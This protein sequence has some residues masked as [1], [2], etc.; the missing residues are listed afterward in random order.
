MSK[1]HS[2]SSKIQVEN[3]FYGSMIKQLNIQDS[4]IST[5]NSSKDLAAA[6]PMTYMEEISSPQENK[7]QKA[8][9][10]E[11]DSMTEQKVFIEANINEALR[12]HL[13]NLSS[14]PN[15]YLRKKENL[16]NSRDGWWPRVFERLMIS[17][18][19]KYFLQHLL[20]GLSGCFFSISCKKKWKVCKFNGKLAFL[21]SLINK[22]VYMA[23]KRNGPATIN[24]ART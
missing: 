6:L 12:R 11:L 23:T 19:K 3:L 24:C 5:L 7:W 18:F 22:P 15:G 9:L 10:E 2:T 17:I 1:T 13:K 16:N 14:V 21:H 4:F 20:L 8:I